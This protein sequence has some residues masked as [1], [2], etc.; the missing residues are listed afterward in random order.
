MKILYIVLAHNQPERL[1]NITSSIINASTDASIIIH[2]DGNAS[3]DGFNKLHSSVANNPKIHLVNKRVRCQWG[4]YSLVDATLESLRQAKK[5]SIDFDYVILLSGA[6]MP[7]KPIKELEKFL[8][9]NNGKE[10]IEFNDENWMIGGLRKERYEFYFPYGASKEKSFI[11]DTWVNIQKKL[12]IKRKTPLDMKVRF[13]SQWWTLT[14]KTCL[15]MLSLLDENPKIETFFK[16]TYIPDEMFFQTVVGHLVP[17]ELITGY[18]L[19]FFK[20]TDYG[21]PIVFYDDHGDYPFNLEKFFVRKVSDEAT[22]LINK[23]LNLV[24]SDDVRTMKVITNKKN[25]DYTYKKKAQTWFPAPGAIYYRDQFIEANGEG[26]LK[27]TKKPYIFIFGTKE[28][29]YKSLKNIDHNIF[30]PMGRIFSRSEVFEDSCLDSICG[31]NTTDKE[32]RDLDQFLYLCRARIR[33]KKIPVFTWVAGDHY[34]PI[35][36]IFNDKNA[37]K[38]IT[39]PYSFD[40]DECLQLL[41]ADLISEEVRNNKIPGVSSDIYSQMLYGEIDDN[42]IPYELRSVFNGNINHQTV[43]Q[44]TSSNNDNT[45]NNLNSF[46]CKRHNISNET[47]MNC[48]FNKYSWFNQII[49]D[50]KKI[51]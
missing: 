17:N 30:H 47:I 31:L 38:I 20:F 51:Q 5:L 48:R 46:I 2:Y 26:V 42:K 15:D 44:Y 4:T 1:S 27:A 3:Q 36:K 32:I 28:Y 37:L 25:N 49:N 19:T 50:L 43:L 18:G 40:S 13:G 34:S 41:K 45:D 16:K 11:E 9:A 7:S 21:K 12:R 29:L 23:S 39:T 10:F 33:T 8:S 6:C 35:R 14:W 22:G 24:H